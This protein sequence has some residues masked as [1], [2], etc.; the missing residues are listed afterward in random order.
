MDV[1]KPGTT[2]I[3][4]AAESDVSAIAALA[5]VVW[6][7]CYPVVISMEQIEYM[8]P[9]MYALNTLRQEIRLA[10]IRY[11]RLL[12]GGEFVGFAAYGPTERPGVFKLHKLYLHPE[13]HG[14]GLGSLLLRHCEAEVGRRGGRRLM[15]NVNKNNAKAIA[16]YQR[17]G[18]VI[19]DSV[20]AEFGGGFVM[21][22]YVMVK[23]LGNSNAF[24]RQS[25]QPAV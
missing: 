5:A 23:E 10:G 11:D 14:R 2:R 15:L 18:F 6:R 13:Y 8:L 3:E 12:V 7:A 22:D 19:A 9:R 24:G 25:L 21:D 16:V 4:P 20:V 17:N 1:G